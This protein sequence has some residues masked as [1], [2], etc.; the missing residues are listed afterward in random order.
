M[1]NNKTNWK[2]V[3]EKF[4]EAQGLPFAE[5]LSEK[6]IRE[7]LEEENIKY[8]KRIYTPMIVIWAFFSQILDGDCSC[9]KV[10]ARVLAFLVS[11]G[12]PIWHA[13]R[14]GYCHAKKRLKTNVFVRL[15]RKIGQETSNKANPEQLWCGRKVKV[16]DGS[17]LL[18]EDTPQNQKQFPQWVNAKP[19]CGFPIAR[20]AAM[21]CLT[22]G[23][24]LEIYLDPMSVN[25]RVMFRRF[26]QNLSPGD[27][28]LADRGGCSFYD[29]A[30][31]KEIGVD[32]VFRIHAS[33]KVDFSKGTILSIED[34]TLTWK[35]PAFSN[36]KHALSLEEYKK[37]PETIFV[38]E[39]DVTFS[40]P[41]YR[42]KKVVLATTLTD[43]SI[44]NKEILM[45]LYFRRWEAEVN[46][47]HLKTTLKME[48]IRAKT[49]DM[50][51]KAVWAHLLVYNLIRRVMWKAALIHDVTPLRISFKGTVDRI[52]VFLPQLTHAFGPQKQLLY[53]IL[54]WNISQDL[55]PRRDGRIYQR[56]IK[57]RP[58]GYPF[59]TK[60]RAEYRTN[61]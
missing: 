23:V 2:K 13:S 59:M 58:K 8:R 22:T 21:F 7:V 1:F 48:M 20:W 56:C 44:Y 25:E 15:V 52:N 4:S 36:K 19:G 24:V 43:S 3:E 16:F 27:I 37:L 10:A 38:R 33:K 40:R 47:R 42:S 49:P 30:M 14:S 53:E 41:G 50:F 32:S 5:A 26:Y 51:R 55:V 29:I 17:S 60:S 34:H 9:R 12:E 35:K 18:M 45:E 46:L 11:Q 28:V 57:R 39:I 31:L 54:L 61:I 6:E